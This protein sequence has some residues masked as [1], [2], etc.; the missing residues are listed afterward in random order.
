MSNETTMSKPNPTTTAETKQPAFIKR[1]GKTTYE[2]HIHFSKTSK[3]TIN[4]KIMRL[5]R[6]DITNT[7]Q[8]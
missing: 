6:N 7:A 1:T 5:I 2:V 3:E 4:D 8:I